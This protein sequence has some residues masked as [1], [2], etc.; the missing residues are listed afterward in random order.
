MKTLRVLVIIALM[1]VGVAASV[2]PSLA[3]SQNTSPPASTTL[4][5]EQPTPTPTPPSTNGPIDCSTGC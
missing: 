3:A 4:Q 5:D 1:V 2:M